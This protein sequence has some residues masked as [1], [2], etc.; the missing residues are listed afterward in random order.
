MDIKSKTGIDFEHLTK[1]GWAVM[2]IIM[3]IFAVV[4]GIEH[5][6]AKLTGL[7]YNEVN[8]IVY[9]LLIPLSWMLMIDYITMLLFLTPLFI[10]AWG[11]FLWKDPMKFRNRCDWVFDKSVDF[12]LYFKKIGWNY[13]V[14][15]VIICVVVPA[16]IYAELIF[17]L[18]YKYN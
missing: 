13:I 6:I 2:I 3:P 15:S 8:I 17:A 4:A 14:S 7:T 12:L 11:I 10:I 5:V 1:T 16:L 9:Y 18:V